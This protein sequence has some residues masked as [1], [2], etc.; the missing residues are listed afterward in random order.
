MASQVTAL[1]IWL[2][3]C[4]LL[5]FGALAEYAFILRQVINLTRKQRRMRQRMQQEQP[6]LMSNFSSP[7]AVFAPGASLTS[8]STGGRNGGPG[9]GAGQ[10][11]DSWMPM[12]TF[13]DSNAM[14]MANTS[15]QMR[16]HSHHSHHHNLQQNHPQVSLE[17][18]QTD[19]G[20]NTTIAATTHH[21]HELE[22]RRPYS[23]VDPKSPH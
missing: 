2:L 19:K 12:R 21:L 22:V 10:S 15:S 7:P 23:R 4:I 8:N 20:A 9:P 6:G 11:A 3:A 1:E 13:A 14:P 18:H 17:T 5:V 16:S